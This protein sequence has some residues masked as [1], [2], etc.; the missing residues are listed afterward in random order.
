MPILFLLY[1]LKEN[2]FLDLEKA[3]GS[4]AAFSNLPSLISLSPKDLH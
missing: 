4:V 2:N 1:S 3:S